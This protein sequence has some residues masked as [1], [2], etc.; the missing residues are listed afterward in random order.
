MTTATIRDIPSVDAFPS[1]AS[2][3]EKL[4]FLLA[5]AVLA[6]SGHNSQ[7]WLF[8]L[9]E[10]SVELLADGSRALPVVDPFDRELTI[11]CGAALYHL[12]LAMRRFG[13]RDRVELCPGDDLDL[14]AR[15]FVVGDHKPTDDERRLFDAIPDRHTNRSPFRRQAVPTQL[16]AEIINDAM[17]EWTWLHRVQKQDDKHSVADLISEGDQLQAA[18]RRF[19]RELAAWLHSNRSRSRDGMPG[20][21][22]G[23]KDV[24]SYAGPFFIRTFDWGDGKAAKDRQL[25]EGSPLL[26]VLGT[27]QDTPTAWLHTGQALARLLLRATAAGVSASFLNQPIELEDLRRR[28]ASLIG[29]PESYPQILLRMGFGPVARPT[30]RRSVEEVLV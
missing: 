19:R 28:L 27:E 24:A 1:A 7:P 2:T 11:S 22:H 25:A 8:R 23:V 5:Y 3:S 6:P 9:G 21:A 15:V 18:D 20:Y 26:V 10:D 12:R 4:R 13:L 17:S 16:V 30:P 29:H 14:L